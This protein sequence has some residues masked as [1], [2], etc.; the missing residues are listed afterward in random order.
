MKWQSGTTKIYFKGESINSKND[1]VTNER[2]K[3]MVKKQYLE[4][5]NSLGNT[6]SNMFKVSQYVR[7][8]N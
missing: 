5:L 3:T 1:N 7:G 4:L 8:Q 2:L 6:Y